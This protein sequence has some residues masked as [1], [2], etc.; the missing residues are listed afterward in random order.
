MKRLLLVAVLLALCYRFGSAMLKPTQD[1]SVYNY[2]FDLSI[3][4]SS[5]ALIQCL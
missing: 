5:A 4:T 1:Q 3:S 2:T